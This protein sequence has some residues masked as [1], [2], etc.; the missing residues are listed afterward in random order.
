[1][2]ASNS[3]GG[4]LIIR[5]ASKVFPLRT[6]PEFTGL[7]LAA[8][9]SKYRKQDMAGVLAFLV[10]APLCVYGFHGSL[11][12]YAGRITPRPDAV[13][14]LTAN[15]GFWYAPA[16]FIGVVVACLLI[17]LGNRMLLTDGGRQYRYWSNATAGFEVSR[18]FF[19]FGL[20]FGAGGLLLAYFAARTHL[21]LTPTELVVRRIW[22]S[23]EEHHPYSHISALKETVGPKEQGSDFIIEF[24]DA[25][26]WS[27]AQ[28]VVFPEAQHKAFIEKMTGKKIE[29]IY[30]K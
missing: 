4:L 23:K 30:N 24:T 12:A 13:H 20:I 3:V 29:T 10:L 21:D 5:I 25:E 19:S 14:Y 9:K 28:E 15:S 22:S 6:P 1:M 18:M 26:P 2:L 11:L 8:L 7:D 17:H 27:T 16:A